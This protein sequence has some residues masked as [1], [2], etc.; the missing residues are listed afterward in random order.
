MVGTTISLLAPKATT[1]RMPRT[2]EAK[3]VRDVEEEEGANSSPSITEV[4]KE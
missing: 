1:V 4:L 2:A 3:V